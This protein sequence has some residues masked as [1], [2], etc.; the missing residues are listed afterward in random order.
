[1]TKPVEVMDAALDEAAEAVDWYSN[2]DED[3]AR[4]F[5]EEYTAAIKV[6][7]AKSRAFPKY[8]H[9]TKRHI[10]AK[11]PYQLVIRELPD[12]IQVVAVAHLR[13]KPGYWKGRLN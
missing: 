1:M 8:L 5:A 9:G 11:Y 3:L 7:G 4:R 12:R 13:R 10:F 6:V 2:I